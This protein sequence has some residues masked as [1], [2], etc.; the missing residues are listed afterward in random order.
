MIVRGSIRLKFVHAVAVLLFLTMAVIQLNDPDPL[1]WFTVYAAVAGL[2][3]SCFVG[4]HSAPVSRIALGMVLAG[5]LMSAPGAVDYM[6]AQDFSSIYGQMMAEKPYVEAA[7]EFGGLAI[8][9][10]YLLLVER[11]MLSAGR[12]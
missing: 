2:A 7:R 8:A 10:L 9:A 11:W 1:Y 6:A 12:A 4:K 5:L 3:G